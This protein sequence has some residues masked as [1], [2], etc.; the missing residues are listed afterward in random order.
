MDLA[1]K[2]TGSRSCH[3]GLAT[4]GNNQDPVT[5]FKQTGSGF[6]LGKHLDLQHFEAYL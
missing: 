5:D 3:Q 2:E 6:A 4:K 1:L